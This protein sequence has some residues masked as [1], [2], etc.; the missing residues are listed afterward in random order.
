MGNLKS[1][2]Y[3]GGAA[4]FKIFECSDPDGTA[5]HLPTNSLQ[6]DGQTIATY[7]TPN[8]DGSFNYPNYVIYALPDKP[9]F[10]EP[11][12]TLPVCGDTPKTECVLYVGTDINNFSE[13]HIFS[14]PFFVTGNASDS[15]QPQGN[16][17]VEGSSGSNTTLIIVGVVVLIVIVG[18]TVYL[19]RRRRSQIL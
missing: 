14:T 4:L 3:P 13:P 1:A 11:P 17:G 9:T 5:A 15:G 2:G 19:L 6:C 16:G 10:S 7:S 12:D 8:A 18:G